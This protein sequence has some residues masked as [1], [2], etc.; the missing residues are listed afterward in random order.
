MIDFI[1]LAPF[2]SLLVGSSLELIICKSAIS[3]MVCS[4]SPPRLLVL[5]Q[6][7]AILELKSPQQLGVLFSFRVLFRS[8]NPESSF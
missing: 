2:C 6:Y 3:A 1:I 8:I 7:P 4:D 5:L